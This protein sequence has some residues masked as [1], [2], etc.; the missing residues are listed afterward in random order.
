M[1]LYNLKIK[2]KRRILKAVKNNMPERDKTAFLDD[3]DKTKR[4]NR[5]YIVKYFEHFDEMGL[6]FTI[7]EYCLVL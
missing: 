2:I 7:S 3:L 1:K 5:P 6:L 4:L